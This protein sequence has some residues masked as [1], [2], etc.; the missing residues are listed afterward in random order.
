MLSQDMVIMQDF[1]ENYE[2]IQHL[3]KNPEAITASDF[4]EVM[5]QIVAYNDLLDSRGLL[6]KELRITFGDQIGTDFNL[7]EL[8]QGIDAVAVVKNLLVNVPDTIREI[9]VSQQDLT[10]LLEPGEIDHSES[11]RNNQYELIRNS[12]C[13]IPD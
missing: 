8:K 9:M 12:Q 5:E 4:C 2:G 10:P 3:F 11:S 1:M 7:Q 6:E 13:T